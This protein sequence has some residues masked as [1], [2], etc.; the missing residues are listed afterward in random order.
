[1]M[2]KLSHNYKRIN[3]KNL[4]EKKREINTVANNGYFF[5]KTI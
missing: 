2:K 5:L 4:K 1:M 3:E